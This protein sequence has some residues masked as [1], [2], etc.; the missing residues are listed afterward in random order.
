MIFDI[1][2]SI[3]VDIDSEIHL[4]WVISKFIGNLKASGELNNWHFRYTTEGEKYWYN[5]TSKKS[6]NTFPYA[7]IVSDH[8]NT[9]RK[10][11]LERADEVTLP[12]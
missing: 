11:L 5:N 8:V 9:I 7:S 3:G 2:I 10:K 4:L 1:A 12:I 6:R